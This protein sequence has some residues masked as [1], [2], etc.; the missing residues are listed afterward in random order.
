MLKNLILLLLFIPMSLSAFGQIISLSNGI[1]ENGKHT[2][3]SNHSINLENYSGFHEVIF[4][5]PDISINKPIGKFFIN[6][7][8]FI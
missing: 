6:N 3:I 2:P 7:I 5:T 8:I 1:L 4:N